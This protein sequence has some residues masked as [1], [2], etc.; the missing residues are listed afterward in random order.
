MLMPILPPRRRSKKNLADEVAAIQ[1][2]HPDAEIQLWAT[3]EHRIG[4]LPLIRKVWAPIGKRP[5]APVQQRYE[6]LSRA[7]WLRPSLH[8]G[9][10]VVAPAHRYRCP[11]RPDARRLCSGYGSQTRETEHAGAGRRWLAYRR[12]GAGARRH[13]SDSLARL[14]TRVAAGRTPLATHQRA[15]HQCPLPRSRHPRGGASRALPHAP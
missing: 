3:D 4:L 1:A 10:R 15:T 11:L 6:W 9:D 8:G 2:A 13:P 5:I 12:G 7:L 14:L